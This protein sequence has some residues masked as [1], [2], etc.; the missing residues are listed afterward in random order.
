MAAPDKEFPRLLEGYFD[1]RLSAEE[2]AALEQRLRSDPAA[3]DEYWEAARW[4][5]TLSEWGEQYAGREAAKL[6]VFPQTRRARWRVWGIAALAAAAAV[7]LSFVSFHATRPALTQQLAEVSFQRDAAWAL[8]L[9]AGE[10]SLPT[11]A[12]RFETT[13][14]ASVSVAAPA[15]FKLVTADRIELA[16]GRLTARMTRPGARLT[17]KVRDLEVTDLGTAF[18][19]DASDSGRALVSVFD[20]LVAVKSRTSVGELRLTRGESLLGEATNAGGIE[21]I[22]YNTEAFREL[23]PL[24]AGIDEVSHLVEFLP[25]GP[26]LRPLRDYR[27]ND[28]VFLFPERQGTVLQQPLA[29]D[30]SAEVC[31][32]PDSPT[33]P[34]PIARGERV[35]S[36]LVFFQ[37]DLAA[38]AGPRRLSG[39]ITFQHRVVGV[40]CSDF[41]LDPSDR[42]VG[43]AEADY[44]TPGQR[45]GL[46][47]DD[48]VNSRGEDLPHDSIVI[49]PD[50]RTVKFDFYVANERDQMRVLV[51]SK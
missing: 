38:P 47:A 20:G 27:A 10:Y 14:G 29:V 4:H 13:A 34:Y 7:A 26:L 40:I 46:E 8:S 17:V 2:R 22:R 19:V 48:M 50:Q 12:V 41:G 32:W 45:R 37:P 30:L 15:R 25:P 18:G 51:E 21:K 39:E 11:G 23:W 35:N 36:Y 42:A 24:T 28:R 33:S 44:A 31:A 1:G 6:E 5:A 49:G 43:L 9:R 3:R 16:S